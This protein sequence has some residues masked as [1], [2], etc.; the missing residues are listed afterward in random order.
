M[1]ATPSFAKIWAGVTPKSANWPIARIR[2]SLR[3]FT[4]PTIRSRHAFS[5]GLQT[6]SGIT[7]RIALRWAIEAAALIVCW[8][9]SAE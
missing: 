5:A 3:V 4:S 9:M 1:S 7:L 2:R 8:I 6:N